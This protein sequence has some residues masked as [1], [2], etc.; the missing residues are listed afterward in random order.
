MLCPCY[1][2]SVVKGLNDRP[3]SAD[4]WL[5]WALAV[6]LPEP[7]RSIGRHAVR[8]ALVALV[9]HAGHD[10]LSWPATQTLADEIHGLTRRDVR[11]ALEVLEAGA[12]IA[13]AGRKGRAICWRLGP[14]APV[15]NSPDMA[16]YPA[17]FT[18]QQSAGI[19]AGELAGQ[20]AG[21]PAPNGREQ[22]KTPPPP[23]AEPSTESWSE[24]ARGLR[25]RHSDMGHE[26]ALEVARRAALDPETKSAAARLTQPGYVVKLR[27]DLKT[28]RD[29]ERRR[30][31]A[32]APKCEDHPDFPAS[33]CREC[34]GD[35]KAGCRDPRFFGKHQ[36]ECS[37]PMCWAPII[38]QRE[39]ATVCGEHSPTGGRRQA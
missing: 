17:S 23:N 7:P 34:H 4:D 11:N 10:C 33:S 19:A 2:R 5:A 18:T 30:A 38:G 8:L 28:I 25:L 35:V 26:E 1:R 9:S 15:D 13:R 36:P 32:T 21:Y 24:L 14:F 39:G 31:L 29:A 27:A 37:V 20:V 16:G 22:K 3:I 6:P 12:V